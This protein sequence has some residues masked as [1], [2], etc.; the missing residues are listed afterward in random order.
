MSVGGRGNILEEQR[1]RSS[2]VRSLM[3]T[4]MIVAMATPGYAQLS[5]GG[6]APGSSSGGAKPGITLGGDKKAKSDD[7]IKYEKELDQAYKSGVSKI[8][9]KK[10]IADPWGNVRGAAT[11]QSNLKPQQPGSK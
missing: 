7:D 9:D 10:V 11:P 8:P 1:E 3:T 4:M 6:G 2:A 5:T